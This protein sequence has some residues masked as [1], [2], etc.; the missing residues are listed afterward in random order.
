MRAGSRL[1]RRPRPADVRRRRDHEIDHRPRPRPV[2]LIGGSTK[3]ILPVPDAIFGRVQQPG[4]YYRPPTACPCWEVNVRGACPAGNRAEP[5]GAFWPPHSSRST[6][7]RTA[8]SRSW[9]SS[10]ATCAHAVVVSVLTPAETLIVA[11]RLAGARP[12]LAAAAGS[13]WSLRPRRGSGR[14]HAARQFHG[15]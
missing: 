3:P 7:L 10:S 5:R 1:S 4:C 13:A 12:H 15:A 14:G 2:G 8:A 9:W 11:R 6:A